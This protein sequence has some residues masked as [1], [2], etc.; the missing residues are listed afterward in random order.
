M[1]CDI[2]AFAW[3]FGRADSPF[4]FSLST[5][6]TNLSPSSFNCRYIRA[7]VGGSLW[8]GQWL[9]ERCVI[10]LIFSSSQLLSL[11]GLLI[12]FSES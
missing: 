1:A 11:P 12:A 6:L 7:A 9:D 4:F 2:Y 5:E 3:R 10:H 8:D